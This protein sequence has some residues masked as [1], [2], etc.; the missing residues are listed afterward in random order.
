MDWQPADD[1]RRRGEPLLG[2]AL[3]H[4]V[5][6]DRPDLAGAAA[7]PGQ[8]TGALLA[9]HLIQ[10]A[11]QRLQIAAGQLAVIEPFI[12][13]YIRVPYPLIPVLE[14]RHDLADVVLAE[15]REIGRAHV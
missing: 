8:L 4:V 15:H 5:H 12:G 9:F 3:V 6:D 10:P 7:Q 1:E 2:D 14:Y 13:D 11:E